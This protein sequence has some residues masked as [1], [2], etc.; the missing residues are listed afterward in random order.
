M[1]NK[2]GDG[3][4]QK[5]LL[6]MCKSKGLSLRRL[7]INSGLSPGT[8]YSIINR[9]YQP[10]LYSLNHLADYLGITREHI[11]QLAG[12][13]EGGSI[14]GDTRMDSLIFRVQRLPEDARNHVVICIEQILS[15][16]ERKST[17][18]CNNLV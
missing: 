9:K 13:V 17:G 11:W 12:L 15:L 6:E 1:G 8:V 16:A 2:F 14:G 5:F 18:T 10:T 3:Q 7:S 4:L